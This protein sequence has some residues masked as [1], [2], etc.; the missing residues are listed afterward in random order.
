VS[1]CAGWSAWGRVAVWRQG[2]GTT[3]RPSLAS[4][5]A[6]SPFG[7]WDDRQT[8][9]ADDMRWVPVMVRLAIEEEEGEPDMV[10]LA[11][12][13]MRGDD[14]FEQQ[15]L[16]T[17]DGRAPGRVPQSPIRGWRGALEAF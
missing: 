4:T 14:R 10:S 15:F 9:N 2:S 8:D 12:A 7:V 16:F 6:S 11:V 1:V 3:L 17:L 13:G 5:G